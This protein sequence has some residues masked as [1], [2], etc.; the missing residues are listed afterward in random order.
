MQ[1][2]KLQQDNHDKLTIKTTEEEI[3]FWCK[4][5]YRWRK[6]VFE[7]FKKM[8]SS[9]YDRVIYQIYN[10]QRYGKNRFNNY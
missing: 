7:R 6:N 4:K 9:N 3:V 2:L 8:G 1:I 10:D 5:L